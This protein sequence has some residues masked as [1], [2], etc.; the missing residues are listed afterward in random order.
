MLA[1]PA[2]D[3]SIAGIIAYQSLTI[4]VFDCE[5]RWVVMRDRQPIV[6]PCACH[7]G[8]PDGNEDGR[9]DVQG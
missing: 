3:L 2:F 8:V 5:C 7:L 6:V 1:S 4:V 9:I